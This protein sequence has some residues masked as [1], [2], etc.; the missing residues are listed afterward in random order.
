MKPDEF[1]EF[2][3]NI[4]VKSSYAI[5]NSFSPPEFTTHLN[6]VKCMNELS[7]GLI[8]DYT[9]ICNKTSVSYNKEADKKV[10]MIKLIRDNIHYEMDII[11]KEMDYAEV[12]VSWIP[13]KCYYL[14]FNLQMLTRYLI[15]LENQSLTIGHYA[16]REDFLSY[17]SQRQITLSEAKFC[18]VI[19]CSDINVWKAKSGINLMT[20]SP[21]LDT[22]A[23]QIAKK[24]SEYKKEDYKRT[25]KLNLR[26][27]AGK[28]KMASFIEKNSVTL[29]EFFYWYRIK[30]NYRDLE[31]MTGNIEPYLFADFYKSYYS[32]TENFYIAYAKLINELSIKRFGKELIS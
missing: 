20:S 29:I 16:L 23:L 14:I 2:F 6:Y 25:Q 8:I 12:C 5:V 11:N 21:D 22:R 27:K 31:F 19:K 28:A 15:T 9:R 13:V 7:T 32:L 26:K 30:T 17:I 3:G 18:A 4:G 24:I 1:K 10:T